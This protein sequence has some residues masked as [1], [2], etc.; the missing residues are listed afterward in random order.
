MN[1]PALADQQPP[2]AAVMPIRAAQPGAL[3]EQPVTWLGPTA[4]QLRAARAAAPEQ[5]RA[6]ETRT[7]ASEPST[8]TTS[9]SG[10][11]HARSVSPVNPFHH[12]TWLRPAS[13]A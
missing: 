9:H 1:R 5:Q 2:V 6:A 7:T 12:P 4:I 8:L 11:S 10:W 13:T 3:P